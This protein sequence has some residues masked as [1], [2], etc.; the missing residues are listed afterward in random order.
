M[1]LKKGKNI[2]KIV[3]LIT[4]MHCVLSNHNVLKWNKVT[5]Y[6]QSRKLIF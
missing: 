6:N 5:T 2:I 3:A 4:D 1:A